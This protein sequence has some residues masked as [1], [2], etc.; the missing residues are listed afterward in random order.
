M[1][2]FLLSRVLLVIPTFIGILLL[3][4]VLVHLIPG[5]PVEIMLGERVQHTRRDFGLGAVV[6]GERHHEQGTDGTAG[7]YPV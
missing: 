6:E 5:D 1:I 7:M 2:R 3:T 4:F